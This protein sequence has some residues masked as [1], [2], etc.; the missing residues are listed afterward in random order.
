MATKIHTNLTKSWKKGSNAL[1]DRPNKAGEG[2]PKDYNNSRGAF[3]K[4]EMF[5]KG[6]K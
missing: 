6:R 5:K 3:K 1:G 2:N 4:G